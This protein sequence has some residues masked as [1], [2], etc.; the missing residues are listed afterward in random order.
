MLFSTP[1]ETSR[2][3]VGKFAMRIVFLYEVQEFF[4]VLA[5]QPHHILLA[6]ALAMFP[7]VRTSPY[8]FH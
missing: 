5:V 4:E 6:E 7:Q 2:E 8:L 3:V 1:Q